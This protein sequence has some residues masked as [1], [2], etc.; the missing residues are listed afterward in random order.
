MNKREKNVVKQTRKVHS[1][2]LARATL[3]SPYAHL[4][5]PYHMAHFLATWGTYSFATWFRSSRC[6]FIL[7]LPLEWVSSFK[8]INSHWLIS[9]M[10][11]TTYDIFSGQFHFAH[12]R[13]V[14]I[15]STVVM[16]LLQ[17][18][19]AVSADSVFWSKGVISF[20]VQWWWCVWFEWFFRFV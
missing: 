19:L 12:D 8:A 3:A 5:F 11:P 16:F 20:P 10:I 9:V 2:K 6:L 14:M 18:L 13:F 7:T 4:V 17:C 1:S 15:S